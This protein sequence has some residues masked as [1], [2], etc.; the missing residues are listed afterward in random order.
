[1]TNLQ[2]ISQNIEKKNM[3]RYS[4]CAMHN[5]TG[6]REER[7]KISSAKKAQRE[8]EA[9]RAQP[10]VLVQTLAVLVNKNPPGGA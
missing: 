6:K 8:R 1:M 9:K 10:F 2:S 4:N 5:V 3:Y 7:K